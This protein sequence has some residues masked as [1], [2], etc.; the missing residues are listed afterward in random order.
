[1][2]PLRGSL[3]LIR[4][5]IVSLSAEKI[6]KFRKKEITPRIGK[7][8]LFAGGNIEG[9]KGVSL[10]LRALAD[11]K[12][13]GIDFHYTIAGG[14]PEIGT[15]QVLCSSLGLNDKVE[16][17]AGYSGDDY[18][19]ALQESDIYFLPSFRESTPVTLMEAYLAGC[20]PVVADASAQGE[21]VRLMGGIAVKAES[22]ETMAKGLA[23]AL[24]W[25]HENRELLA[26]ENAVAREKVCSY[27]FA[28]R[29]D[30][31]L[32]EAYSGAMGK[33]S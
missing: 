13:R 20:Y 23:D 32:T 11:V 33:A 1:M 21:I 17:H 5:P 8:R 15:L 3:P 10:A 2:K 16:F 28:E 19:R 12:A 4:L 24:V 6:E 22:Q 26:D 18:I 14:G 25:C 30:S 29:Y 31:I 7:L 9:R 27:F